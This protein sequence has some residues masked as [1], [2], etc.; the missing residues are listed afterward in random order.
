DQ[1]PKLQ[2]LAEAM[3]KVISENPSTVFM[4]EGH[5]DAVGSAED[6]LSLSDRRAESVAE[7][8]TTNFNVPPE[9]MVTQGY[10][11]QYL[12]VQTAGPTRANRR[13]QVRNITGLMAGGPDG[14]Q[15]G[16][17]PDGPPGQPPG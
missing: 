6:N 4:M 2:A 5:T 15:G 10:G 7:I 13:V 17:P 14:Q 3:L 1:I 11:E 12:R 8:L 16:P 9:N